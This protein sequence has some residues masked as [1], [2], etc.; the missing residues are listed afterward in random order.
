MSGAV[1]RWR[2]L[3]LPRPLDVDR[4]VSLLRQLSTDGNT[5]GVVFEA[6]GGAGVV[7]YFVGAAPQRLEHLERLIIGALPGAQLTVVTDRSAVSAVGHVKVSTRHRALRVDDPLPPVRTV[8]GALAAARTSE[9]T[10][11]QVVL[12]AGRVPL[13]IPNQSS[14]AV[15]APLWQTLWYGN[16][17]QLDGEKRTALRAKVA[18]HGFACVVR[19]GAEA[20]STERRRA[21]VAGIL[22]ALRT[23]EAP[24]VRLHLRKGNVARFNGGSM[25]LLL[26]S[27]RLSVRELLVMLAWGI[28]DSDLP[29]HAAIHP[30]RLPPVP[31]VLVGGRVVA[32]SLAP[33]QE[34]SLLRLS[35]HDARQHLHVL[36]P[37]G[38]GKSVLLGHL[39][40]QDIAAGRGVVV[41]EPK[42]DLVDA[43]LSQI[44][45][46]RM[47][48]VVIL[49]PLDRA[50]IGLNPL[51][52]RGGSDATVEGLVAVFRAL[53]GDALGPRSGDVLHSALLTLVRHPNA[54]LVMLPLLLTN[55]GFRR[56]IT[57]G[58]HDPIGLG[59][60]WAW[61]DA[62]SE[63]ER[64]TVIAPLMNKLRPWLLNPRLRAVIGQREPR[65][66]LHQVFTERKILLVPL[67]GA[68]IGEEAARLL[69]SLAV[70]QLWQTIQARAVVPPERRHTV[71]VY[72]D[73]VQDYLHLPTDLAD[74]FAQARGL[75]VGFTVAHQFMGQ[76][77]PTMQAGVL[78][79]ARSRVCFQLSHADAVTAAR[80]HPELTPDDLTA[81]GAHEVYA[82]LH[83]AGKSQP[84]AMGE[85]LPP[86]ATISEAAE[87][88]ARSRSRY[89]RPLDEVEASFL[90][91]AAPA[92]GTMPTGRRR[93]QS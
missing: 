22:A 2:E 17:G 20:N 32:R 46:E 74:A 75:G 76:L 47:D 44:P 50:P 25:P 14:A 66:G 52:G 80:G 4:V 30:R 11:L 72:V 38:V 18:D 33:G 63:G 55:E 57:Q 42:G 92:V 70:A 85:T 79:N 73:E 6:R 60:F 13:A 8:L 37:T 91:L 29:G 78:A 56:S 19:I 12:G 21:L 43:V 23:S 39:I 36:G 59:P 67:R 71:T 83:A 45:P 28:G 49:D 10:V 58:I 35:A 68:S 15:A 40:A 82:S 86:G 62:L 84:Y 31:A 1:L 61:F 5:R 81:L 53:Y 88:R 7:R 48:D 65:F 93:R 77:S 87:I 54:S 41:I 26:W 90:E 89:G 24:G 34:R 64:R 3:H 16:G 9:T 27:L 51:G 69:G